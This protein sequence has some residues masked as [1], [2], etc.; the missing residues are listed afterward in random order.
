MNFARV[1][2]GLVVSLKSRML[3]VEKPLVLLRR[4]S[5]VLFWFPPLNKGGIDKKSH[6]SSQRLVCYFE[7]RLQRY[8]LMFISF[9]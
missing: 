1:L 7:K 4:L 6:Y 2:K 3:L 8:C 5:S 9:G